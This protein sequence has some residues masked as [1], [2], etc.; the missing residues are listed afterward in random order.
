MS[1]SEGRESRSCRNEKPGVPAGLSSSTAPT[2][3]G[4]AEL[5]TRPR[6]TRASSRPANAA[7]ATDRIHRL[8]RHGQAVLVHLDGGGV[9]EEEAVEG[10]EG[11]LHTGRISLSHVAHF[12]EDAHAASG[13]ADI[14]LLCG[15]AETWPTT[16][17]EQSSTEQLPSD[18]T[19]TRVVHVLHQRVEGVGDLDCWEL[20]DLV[21]VEQAE[22]ARKEAGSDH[23][24]GAGDWAAPYHRSPRLQGHG[25]QLD[26]LWS[27][28]Q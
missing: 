1:C 12:V 4:S 11:R 16:P 6:W 2:R 17:V 26:G 9:A 13:Q 10:G 19:P 28:R 14:E 5:S 15:R 20:V 8:G 21:A 24:V 25:C 18:P 27:S 23:N 22:E 7:S 3:A